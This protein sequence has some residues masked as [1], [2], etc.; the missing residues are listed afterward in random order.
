MFRLELFKIRMFSAGN[1]SS[2]LSSVARGGLQFMLVIWLQGI[3]LPLHGYSFEQTPLWSGIYMSPLLIGFIAM[4]LL[5]GWLS[6][7]FGARLFSTGGM[8]IQAVGFIGL[9]LLPANFSYAPFALVL[10]VLGIGSG[11]FVAPNT[12]QIMNSVPPEARGAASGMRATFQNAAQM[13]SIGV[14][15]TIVVS[16]LAGS[17]P[18][19]L[20]LGLTQ[21]G[22]APDSANAIAQLPPTSALFGAFLGY[23]PIG[24]LLPSAVQQQLS[25]A[26]L[27]TLLSTSFFPNLISGP[28]LDGLRVVFYVAT[29]MCA[30][31]AAALV[32]AARKPVAVPAPTIEPRPA[33]PVGEMSVVTISRQY[34]SGGGEVGA[35]LAR[36]LGW[37]LLDRGVVQRVAE[38]LHLTEPQAEERDERAEPFIA[39]LL[40]NTHS[41][42]PLLLND[43]PAGLGDVHVYRETVH[44]VLESAA[45]IGHVVIIGRGGMVPLAGRP[46]VL[47]V[48]VVAPLQPR[49]AYVAYR[50][51]LDPA[52]ARQRLLSKDRDR[53]HY[54]W[55]TYGRRADDENLYDLVLNTGVLDLDTVVDEI[56]LALHRAVRSVQTP[57]RS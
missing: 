53:E 27:S 2:F 13:V 19:A 46:D 47:D 44:R 36:R 51:G 22:V 9:S 57:L 37:E 39:R 45:N 48:R 6:Q 54:L 49:I 52:A 56:C 18:Q 32:L 55:A 23:N 43:C 4:G 24:V 5:S 29:A 26:D 38:E 30:A 3:W 33:A 11:L 25:P 15:F 35:R 34:G 42:D 7:R 41:L 16:G 31:G 21:N 12:T 17:L 10:L 40:A 14:F 28:F 50:E 8:I 20:Y 1:L